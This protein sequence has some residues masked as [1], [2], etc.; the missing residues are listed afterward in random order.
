M[1]QT[2]WDS[3]EVPWA[4]QISSTGSSLVRKAE[5]C[6]STFNKVPVGLWET[7][8][9]R[10]V[11]ALGQQ[12]SQSQYTFEV[13]VHGLCLE[14]STQLFCD[15]TQI[16]FY[17]YFYFLFPPFLTSPPSFIK[18]KTVSNV[19]QTGLEL[20]KQQRMTLNF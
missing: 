3:S 15:G 5:L 11:P 12:F 1:L 13:P 8:E 9:V 16:S 17:F 4:L 6:T 14:I 19:S 18:N 20:C 2:Q 10:G 7:T